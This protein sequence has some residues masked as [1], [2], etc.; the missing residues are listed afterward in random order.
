MHSKVLTWTL[1]EYEGHFSQFSNIFS[2]SSEDN[3]VI[4]IIVAAL[5]FVVCNSVRD[6]TQF[7]RPNT[8][9]K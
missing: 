7:T 3:L 1:E 6:M 2:D 5:M 4:E 9:S 8:T